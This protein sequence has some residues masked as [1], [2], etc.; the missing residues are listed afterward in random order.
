MPE[1]TSHV[2][3][4]HFLVLLNWGGMHGVNDILNL[5]I[6]GQELMGF[7]DRVKCWWYSYQFLETASFILTGKFKVLKLDLKKW[8][9]KVFGNIDN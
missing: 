1:E 4:D 3:L 2:C 8:N 7:L 9:T 5:K 6:C